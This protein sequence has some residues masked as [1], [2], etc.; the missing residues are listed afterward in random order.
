MGDRTRRLVWRLVSAQVC[1]H[2]CMTGFRMAA[3]LMALRKQYG[4]RFEKEHGVKLGFMSL[5]GKIKLIEMI[6]L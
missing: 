3:P 1:L 5:W 2:A 4:E 6:L